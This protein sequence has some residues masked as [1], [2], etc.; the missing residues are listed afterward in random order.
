MVTFEIIL[1]LISL[2]IVSLIC[3]FFIHT[4]DKVT[5]PKYIKKTKKRYLKKI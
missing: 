3:S 1:S 4:L 2:G 5:R